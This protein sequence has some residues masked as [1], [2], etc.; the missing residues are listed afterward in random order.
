MRCPNSTSLSPSR[1]DWWGTLSFRRFSV[2]SAPFTDSTLSKLHRCHYRTTLLHSDCLSNHVRDNVMHIFNEDSF[3]YSDYL[4]SIIVFRAMYKRPHCSA[5]TM[6]SVSVSSHLPLVSCNAIPLTETV[7]RGTTS[8]FFH[9][10][11]HI[12]QLVFCAGEF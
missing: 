9:C 7:Q 3:K 5:S 12:R 1:I 2:L 6:A 4:R 8:V 11:A 10:L